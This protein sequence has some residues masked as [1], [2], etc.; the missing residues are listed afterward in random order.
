MARHILCVMSDDSD[1]PAHPEPQTAHALLVHDSAV[2]PRRWEATLGRGWT[3][4]RATSQADLPVKL[5]GSV[6]PDLVIIELREYANVGHQLVR[7][8]RERPESRTLPV[9]VLLAPNDETGELMALDD[10]ADEVLRQPLSVR[11]TRARARRLADSKGSR[12]EWAR[13]VPSSPA[14]VPSQQQMLP[15]PF[16]VLLQAYP[17]G[18]VLTAGSGKVAGCSDEFLKMWQLVPAMISNANEGAL[19]EAMG[20]AIDPEA[21]G[22]SVLQPDHIN[23]LLSGRAGDVPIRDGRRLRLIPIDVGVPS[24]ETLKVDCWRDVSEVYTKQDWRL[25]AF[26]D[27]LIGA[28]PY[29]VYVKDRNSRF[30]KMNHQLAGRLGLSDPGLGA[31]KSDADFHT[32]RYAERTHDEERVVMETGKPLI[33]FLHQETWADGRISWNL[34]TKVPLRDATGEVRGLFGVSHDVTTEREH[35]QAILDL[36]AFAYSVAHD[37][38]APVRAVS[39]FAQILGRPDETLTPAQRDEYLSRIGEAAQRMKRIIENILSL[40]RMSFAPLVRASVDLSALASELVTTFRRTYD[41]KPF[42]VEIAEGLRADADPGL[43]EI[44]MTNLLSNAVKYSAEAQDPLIEIGQTLIDG[45]Q[46]YFVKDNGIGFDESEMKSLFQR[47]HR[48]DYKS[49]FSG[50]GIGLSTVK[51]IIDRHHGDIFARATKGAGACFY[52]KLSPQ[53]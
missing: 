5:E 15:T 31:G 32:Q 17:D 47:F 8:M 49:A 37:L 28:L 26:V 7:L 51:R 4:T 2:E 21:F 11:S 34:S 33:G 48:L 25:D 18:L 29:Q 38:R 14:E 35:R 22:Q 40:S 46:W 23:E 41:K 6:M 3:L 10:G 45:Q 52:F 20:Q 53:V 44:A 13:M 36:E 42:K 50:S 1:T 12:F 39:G 43:L 19:R 16:K 24:A 27:K 9:M 30:V